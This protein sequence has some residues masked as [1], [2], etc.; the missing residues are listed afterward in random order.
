MVEEL[1]QQQLWLG[2]DVV[3]GSAVAAVSIVHT[4]LTGTSPLGDA[5]PTIRVPIELSLS[6]DACLQDIRQVVTDKHETSGKCNWLYTKRAT[7]FKRERLRSHALTR[8]QP[9]VDHHLQLKVPSVPI[10]TILQVHRHFCVGTDW[11]QASPPRL[12][13]SQNHAL[14][15][16]LPILSTRVTLVKRPVVAGLLQEAPSTSTSPA[17]TRS[18]SGT[19][20]TPPSP[21]FQSRQIQI[22][23][24]QKKSDTRIC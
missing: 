1:V 17:T 11:P 19:G 15:S 2:T 24:Q 4:G 6:R 5:K 3:L 8:P 23:L 9:Q 14:H 21:F 18:I 7:C 13:Q 16:N 12:Y 22:Q 20:L 10:E